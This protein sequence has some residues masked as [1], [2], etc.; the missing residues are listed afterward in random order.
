MLTKVHVCI[1]Y[2]IVFEGRRGT[3]YRGDIAL[4]DISLKDGACP[5]SGTVHQQLTSVERTCTLLTVIVT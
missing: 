1:F 4:D 2:Q 5:S 3:S